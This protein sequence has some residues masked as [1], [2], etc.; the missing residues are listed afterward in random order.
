LKKKRFFLL[1]SLFSCFYCFAQVPTAAFTSDITA[2]CA[3]IIVNFHDQSSGGV[4][5]WNWDFG[6]GSTSTRQHPS[7]TYITPGTYTVTLTA[8]NAAGTNTVTRTSYITVYD[9]PAANFTSNKTSGCFPAVIQ[10]TDQSGTQPGTVINSW[11]WDFGDGSSSTQKNPQYAY[12]AAGSYTVTLTVTND[13]GCKKLITKPN[14]INVT[15][16]VK[17]GFEYTDPGVCSAPA[18][19]QFNNKSSG[20]GTLTYAWS[21]GNGNTSNTIDPSANY[22]TNGLYHIRLIV[23]SNQGCSDSAETD[24]QVGRVNTDFTNA[25]VICPKTQVSF[26]NNS[27]PRPISAYWEISN[28]HTDNLRNTSTSFP[29]AGTYTVKLVN[30][31]S[32]C[33]DTLVKT[34]TVQPGPTINFNAADTAKCQPS[35]TVNFTNTS[36]GTSYLWDFGDSTSSTTANPS[37]TYNAFGTYDVSLIATAANGCVDTLKKSGYIK[38]QKPVISFPN[39]PIGGCIPFTTTLSAAI[40]SVDSVVTYNWNFGDGTTPSD[41]KTPTHTYKDSGTYTVTLTITTRTGC[42]ETFT[43]N[44]AIKAGPTPVAA[45]SSDVT[46]ACADPGIQFINQSTR[47]TQWY[48]V[49][50]DGTTSTAENPRVTF[51]DTGWIDVTLYAIN[52]GCSTMVV[53][54]RYAFIKPSVSRFTYQPNCNNPLSVVFTDRSIQASSWVWNFGDGTTFNGQNPPAHVFPALGTYTVTLTTTN[55]AC[56]YTLARTVTLATQTPDFTSANREGC[57]PF[58]T[59]I[60]ATPPDQGLIKKYLWDFGDNSPIDSTQGATGYHT[61]LK[62][63]NYTIKLTTID[64]FGCR[65]TAIKN[66]FIRVN[67]PLAA[68]NSLSNAGCKGTTVTFDDATITDGTNAIVNWRWD[69]GDSTTGTFTAPPFQHTYD[70]VGD[71]D[72]KLVVTDAKGCTDSIMK[73]AFV[74]ISTLKANW[75]TSGVT[76]PNVTVGFQNLTV[77]DLPYTSNWNFGDG[78]GSTFPNPGHAYADT[79]YYNITLTVQ[80]LIGCRDSLRQDSSIKV[81]RPKASFTA[82]NLTSYCTPFEG[83]FFNTSYFYASSFWDLGPGQGTSTQQSPTAYYNN[84]GSYPIKLVVTGP[85]GCKDSTTQTLRIFSAQDA[86]LTYTPTEG[87]TPLTVSF[88]AFTPMNGRFIWDFG[89]GNVTDTTVNTINHLYVDYGDF[90][91]LVILKEPSGAC[92]I[93]LIGAQPINLLGAKLNFAIDSTTFCDNGFIT[94]LDSTT[95]NDPSLQYTWNFGDGTTSTVQNPTH[96]YDSIGTFDV[97]L[98]VR[99][100]RGC[101]DTLVKGPVKISQ[102]PI[103]SIAADSIICLTDKVTYNGIIERTDTPTLTWQWSFPNGNSSGLQNPPVQTYTVPGSYSVSVRATNSSGC[104]DSVTQSL[105][106]NPLPVVTMPPTLTKIVGVPVTL[107][108][109]YSPNVVSY[110]WTPG[111]DLSCTDCPAPVSTTKFNT[112]YKVAA[113]DSNG[114]TNSGIMQV[115]VL[116]KGATLFVPNTF[117]P[118]GDGNNEV[119]YVRGVGLDRVKSFRIFNRWG[120]IVFEQRDFAVN[121]PSVGWNGTYKGTKAQADVYIYQAEIFC[122]NGEIIRFDGNINLIR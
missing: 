12:R 30:T 67:G 83:Q 14:F 43:L 1:I 92:T 60:I 36:N 10:F 102:S 25:A 53:K 96:Q 104:A 65:Y 39:L 46:N 31:Y 66:S 54:P 116:C 9:E 40:Q 86:K 57:K 51:R 113:V 56:T 45:F 74:K 81:A 85:G 68:F 33:T 117:S 35:L 16:G 87:C 100:Q 106:I 52:N 75:T 3:P 70:S 114:C 69:F 55:S 95:T 59:S 50:S 79:G 58:E 111:T 8:T 121:N 118:N 32:V 20:P 7:T 22:T 90:T 107:S 28:G 6:N 2:G 24:I 62:A 110:L 101:L 76:C 44:Q 17:A 38:I 26:T 37:H 4:T 15:T 47:A 63:G 18:T 119:L 112:L 42:T 84:T 103:V 78:Q 5:A 82:N 91:P 122:E 19:I 29:S 97:T 93:P 64:S 108:P 71:Y 80:D 61:F 72:V 98:T 94:I 13:K 77:S 27:T 21:F 89:D 105:V 73:R 99:T 88:D 34:I 120:E 115:I 49:F 109:T 11:K 23:S 48:W 41:L